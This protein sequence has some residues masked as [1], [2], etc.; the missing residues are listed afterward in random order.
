MAVQNFRKLYSILELRDHFRNDST[1]CCFSIWKTIAAGCNILHPLITKG[2]CQ[3]F[4][5]F[6]ASSGQFQRVF[7]DI[8]KDRRFCSAKLR[9]ATTERLHGSQPVID[10]REL[11]IPHCQFCLYICLSTLPPSSPFHPPSLPLCVPLWCYLR[12][13]VSVGRRWRSVCLNPDKETNSSSNRHMR[14]RVKSEEG[15]GNE[16]DKQRQNLTR[17][18]NNKSTPEFKPSLSHSPTNPTKTEN[19]LSSLVGLKNGHWQ[20]SDKPRQPIQDSLCLTDKSQAWWKGKISHTCSHGMKFPTFPPVS[21]T[22]NQFGREK[23]EQ[24]LL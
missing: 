19:T 23:T 14:E 3:E 24:H 2:G 5:T 8:Y 7:G 9:K 4:P 20:T 15:G 10:G 13:C 17:I 16:T 6:Q 18:P 22:K 21:S 12:V 11:P 1:T